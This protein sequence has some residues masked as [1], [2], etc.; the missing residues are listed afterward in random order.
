[1]EFIYK[2]CTVLF[3]CVRAYANTQS[4]F[5]VEVND[6]SMPKKTNAWSMKR[7]VEF[8]QMLWTLRSFSKIDR[9]ARLHIDTKLFKKT[10]CLSFNLETAATHSVRIGNALMFRNCANAP[11]I[12]EQSTQSAKVTVSGKFRPLDGSQV[13]LAIHAVSRPTAYHVNDVILNKCSYAC[14]AKLPA[15]KPTTACGG[16]RSWLHWQ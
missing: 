3:D 12:F 15:P 2:R 9:S 7:S 10:H 16:R 14:F 5:L 13:Q 4:A 6:I 11:S 8:A 1:M